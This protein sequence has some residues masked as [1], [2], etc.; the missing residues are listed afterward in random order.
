M[1]AYNELFESFGNGTSLVRPEQ[2]LAQATLYWLTNPPPPG[3]LPLRGA[4]LR[5]RARG[6]PGRIGVAVFK[7]DFQTIRALAE[8]DNPNIPHWSEFPRGGHYAALE[9][10]GRRRRSAGVLQ[11]RP[12]TIGTVR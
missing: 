5:G 6:Q 8:R 4:A 12:L 9:V 7:D 1:L 3:P 11:G 2:V 10:P